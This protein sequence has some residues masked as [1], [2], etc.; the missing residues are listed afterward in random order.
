MDRDWKLNEYGLFKGDRRLAGSGEDTVYHR[1][2]LAWVPPEL[3]E[4]RGEIQ[5]AADGALPGLIELD[6]V[7]GDLHSH[8]DATDGSASIAE[9][10]AAAAERG[11]A[12]QAITDHSKRVTMANGLDDDA[13]LAHAETVRE[14]GARHDDLWL[15]A[16][17]EVDILKD[18]SLDLKEATL[19]ELDWVVAS[20]HYDLGQDEEAV[21]ERL[22]G[23]VRSGVV[24]AIGHPTARLLS[25]RAPVPFDADRVF[26]A[27]AQHGVFLEINAQ[28]D[29]LDLPDTYCKRAKE[30]G[31][32]F[33]IGTDAH[34]PTELE[35]L[36]YG[37]DVA[38]RGWLGRDDVI[39][40]RSVAELR[41]VLGAEES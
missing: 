35:F 17:I 9:M 25:R 22:L 33:T 27:C 20:L 21:T 32:R 40:T 12:F 6:D 14:E 31:V 38:R 41:E 39:N 11:R 16:G 34:R 13:A 28:P 18:G 30:A 8:T 7:R 24:H 1:L 4:D 10:A 5:A 15:L 37:V 19:A 3:R 2:N 36:R 23:A 26:E 29:R